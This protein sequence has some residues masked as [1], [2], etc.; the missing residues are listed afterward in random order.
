VLTQQ[1]EVQR[2]FLRHTQ[3]VGVE[4]VGHAA[5]AP[6]QIECQVNGV[7]LDVRQCM[8]EAGVPFWRAHRA[9]LDL[10]GR[11]QLRQ[12]GAPGNAARLHE[13]LAS[14]NGLGQ[15][16]AKGACGLLCR[17]ANLKEMKCLGS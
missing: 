12:R 14:A 13:L 8:N 2:F 15:V 7:Q 1:R 5:E 10:R 17:C 11:H 6:D 3:P 16:Q 9:R 4:L